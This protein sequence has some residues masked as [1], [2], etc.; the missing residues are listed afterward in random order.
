MN[1]AGTS[2]RLA[3]GPITTQLAGQ[4]GPWG[5][6]PCE[7]G[8]QLYGADQLLPLQETAVARRHGPT[9]ARNVLFDPL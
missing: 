5:S 3:A 1:S 7:G 6:S 4:R 9:A 2:G 8:R